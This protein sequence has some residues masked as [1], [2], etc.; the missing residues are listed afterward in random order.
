MNT[1]E[2]VLEFKN[3]LTKFTSE[4]MKSLEK[5]FPGSFLKV[6]VV[7]RG[8][9]FIP[10][11]EALVHSIRKFGF[12]AKGFET[13][14]Y[15]Y[16]PDVFLIINPIQYKNHRFNKRDFIYVGIQTEQ[17]SN[18]EVYC[19]EMGKKNY[20]KLKPCFREYDFIFEWSP[21]A[22]KYLKKKHDNVYFFPHCNF[23]ALQYYKKH[24]NIEEKY[25]LLFIG[26]PTGI[27]NRREDLL[28]IL[29]DRYNVY[30][31]YEE[32]WGEEKEKA[33]LASKICLNIHFDNALVF[34]S[35]RMYEYLANK[36]FVLTE[37][38][39]NSYPFIEGQDYDSFYIHNIL[40]KIDYYLSNQQK[41]EYIAQN[42]YNKINR[43]MLDEHIYLILERI[44][45]EKTVRA[46]T[47]SIKT[48]I[49]R[50]L[51]LNNI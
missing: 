24:P 50:K 43:F 30:P 27:Y 22:Y 38:I 37:R 12:E 40:D 42:G 23:E 25:D 31:K 11:R 5:L 21:T 16:N 3:N 17:I 28:K 2:E 32:L 8:S 6:A 47:K 39:S 10:Y 41:R 26:W 36:K 7:G 19:I 51:G 9:H 4:A 33:I 29:S 13:L 45:L 1:S 35:P 48:K 46:N 15:D 14:E 20:N 49:F 34:E 18:G 44:L